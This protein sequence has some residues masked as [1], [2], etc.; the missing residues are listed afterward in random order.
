VLSCRVS[1]AKNWTQ[2]SQK[3]KFRVR[4]RVRVKGLGL[5]LRVEGLGFR[6]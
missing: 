2:D 1:S 5:G 6:V 3:H 4:V